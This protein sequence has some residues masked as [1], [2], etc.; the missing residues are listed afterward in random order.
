MENNREIWQASYVA[1]SSDDIKDVYQKWTL[2]YDHDVECMGYVAPKLISNHLYHWEKDINARILDV[3]CGT[4]LGGL[5]LKKIGYQNID[6]LDLSHTMLIEARS[7]NIYRRLMREDLTKPLHVEPNTYDAI[8]CVGT[9]THGHVKADALD[10]IL[11]LAK[12]GGHFC[13]TI[14]EGVY[15]KYEFKSK[16]HD[17]ETKGVWKLMDKTKVNYLQNEGIQ[18]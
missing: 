7:K 16:I 8:I 17:L 2:D 15:E 1:T 10:G 4:G 12:P 14:H 9:F 18:A 13:F 11:K 6:G 3:G 5:E